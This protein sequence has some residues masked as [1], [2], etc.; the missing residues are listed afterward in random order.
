MIRSLTISVLIVVVLG[1]GAAP[2]A[3]AGTQDFTLV[4]QTGVEIYSLFISESSNDD[5]EE[6]V[7]GDNVLPDGSRLDIQFA[8]RSACIW[9]MMVTD[10]QGGNATW[11]G[12]NLCQA[13]VVVLRCNDQG[14]WAETE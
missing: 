7:L 3:L 9:D 14:C 10:D 1:L 2:A 4:N 6:D 12:I 13:S 5:W 8:G 11:Q